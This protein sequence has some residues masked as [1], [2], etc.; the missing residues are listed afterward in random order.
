MGKF[1]RGLF[2]GGLLGAGLVLL[3]TTKE[4]RALRRDIM[5]RATQVYD[6][7]S[8]RVRQSGAWQTLSEHEYVTI[9]EDVV[10]R[11]A[12]ENGLAAKVKEYLV[13]VVSRQWKQLQ[14]ELKAEIKRLR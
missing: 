7:V 1:N 9:V 12:V 5:R 4:G 3:N 13:K 6:E 2:V 10:N 11:Y 14:A 8:R